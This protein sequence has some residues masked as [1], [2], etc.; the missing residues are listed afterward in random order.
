MT[1]TKVLIEDGD[2]T[3]I[4]ST[5]FIRDSKIPGGWR[6][7]GSDEDMYLNGTRVQWDENGLPFIEAKEDG[8]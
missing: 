1:V 5:A 8:L 4:G 7:D 3:F 6:W 2:K